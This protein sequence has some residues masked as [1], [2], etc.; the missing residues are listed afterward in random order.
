MLSLSLWAV[1]LG[2][3]LTRGSDGFLGKY[4]FGTTHELGL[5]AILATIA[6]LLLSYYGTRVLP[7]GKVKR[8]FY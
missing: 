3:F 8:L 1:C 7:L 4:V 2:G 6:I 5:A